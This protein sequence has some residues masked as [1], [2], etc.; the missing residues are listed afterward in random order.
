[1]KSPSST[2]PSWFASERFSGKANFPVASGGTPVLTGCYLGGS[3]LLLS[4]DFCSVRV[5]R[6]KSAIKEK[7][8]LMI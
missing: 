3:Y 7:A 5:K 6:P 1:M 8:D 2:F 4:V